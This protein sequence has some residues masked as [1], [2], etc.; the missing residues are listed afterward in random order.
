MI[1]F[2]IKP[3]IAFGLP[4]LL[5][6]LFYIGMHVLQTDGRSLARCTVTWLPNFLGW[7]SAINYC[8]LNSVTLFFFIKIHSKFYSQCFFIFSSE[9]LINLPFSRTLLN[10]IDRY[11]FFFLSKNIWGVPIIRK[12][13]CSDR[14]DI[15]SRTC[16]AH[17]RQHCTSVASVS[18]NPN[19]CSQLSNF[20][21][22]VF[23][24]SNVSRVN[25]S[26]RLYYVYALFHVFPLVPLRYL[27]I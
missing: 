22:I 25:V 2:Q 23:T 12:L 21:Q 8:K 17:L 4:Y 9:L 11:E 14:Y 6:E 5:I 27:L 19:P 16:L 18:G 3:W 10:C 13:C 1:S 20:I 26:R 24:Y 7:G 15:S